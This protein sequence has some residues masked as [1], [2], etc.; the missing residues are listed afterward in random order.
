MSAPLPALVAVEDLEAR[1]PADITD[2]HD[3]LRA[4]KLLDDAS[5]LVR[6]EARNNFVN[7]DGDDTAPDLVRVIVLAAAKRAWFNPAAIETQQLGAVSVRYGD[8]WLTATERGQLAS[9]ISGANAAGV[10]ML[11]LRH[12]FGFN[13]AVSDEVPVDYGD[14]VG[15]GT[16]DGFPMPRW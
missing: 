7:D 8:V 16:A 1:L 14:G 10:R 13:G 15:I 3:R 2:A 4:Q 6:H 12:G 5:V 9:I 11:E